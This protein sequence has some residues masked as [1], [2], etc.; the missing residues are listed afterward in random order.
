MIP[1]PSLVAW[2]ALQEVRVV[3]ADKK[4]VAQASVHVAAGLARF[5]LAGRDPWQAVRRL[6][7]T[8]DEQGLCQVSDLPEGAHLTV[9]ARSEKSAGRAEGTPGQTIEVVLQPTG[10]LTGK[11]SGKKNLKGY[12]VHAI[13]PF[14]TW[15]I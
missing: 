5:D 13:G 2:L 4:P 11:V 14:E 7:L 12:S 15:T 6:E 1:C 10:T 3:G 9:F 8:S